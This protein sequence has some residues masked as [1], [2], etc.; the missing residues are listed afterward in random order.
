MAFI[1]PHQNFAFSDIAQHQ[2]SL[3]QLERESGLSLFQTSQVD[4]DTI[5]SWCQLTDAPPPAATALS[6]QDKYYCSQMQSCEEAQF[7]LNSC[8]IDRL[9]KDGD[10]VACE[11]LCY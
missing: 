3:A 11:S 6:C 4:R 1:I 5:N 9:D 2:V 7:Y 10:G 8:G